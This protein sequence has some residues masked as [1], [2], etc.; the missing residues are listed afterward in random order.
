MVS[1]SS[2]NWKNLFKLIKALKKRGKVFIGISGGIDS[3]A[4]VLIL[5]NKGY[6]VTGVY[7]KTGSQGEDIKSLEALLQIEII[8]R[9][10]QSEFQ[11]QIV[12]PFVED[13][14]KGL[15]P[16]PCTECNPKIKWRYIQQTAMEHSAELWATGH[17]CNIEKVNG[18][19]Y[20]SKG[21]DPKKDQSYYL[22]QLSQQTLQGAVFPLG[23]L[24]KE[25]VYQMMKEQG[26][27]GLVERAQSM[28]ICFL[29]KRSYKELL[30]EMRPELRNLN[31]GEIVDAKGDAI[32]KHC[33]YPFYTIAQKKGLNLP[34]GYCITEIDPQKNRITVGNKEILYSKQITL[35]NWQFNC[36]E[37][38]LHCNQLE[39]KVRGIG[40]NPKGF[41]NIEVKGAKLQ[42]TLDH[43]A[44]AVAKGQPVVFYIKNRLV[45][46]GYVEEFV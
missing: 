24:T 10:I 15:T 38:A 46:G 36:I 39:A 30:L 35:T 26:Y 18:I 34:K 21:I 6:S 14:I 40:I 4:S 2:E 19:Y 7:L 1:L 5:K 17:Y 22:W 3:A 42:V 32:A 28:G 9:D 13:Y 8:E 43:P 16:S 33:G 23:R 29:K 11:K 12:Q 37:E 45:G 44:W 41:C 20:I 27:R 31:H 25:Q